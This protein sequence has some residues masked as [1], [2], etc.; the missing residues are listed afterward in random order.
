[1]TE[2]KFRNEISSFKW[3]SLKDFNKLS[4]QEGNY[5][6]IGSKRMFISRGQFKTDKTHGRTETE[7]ENKIL[8]ADIKKYIKTL[9]K[10]RNVF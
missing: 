6:V 10:W 4:I 1:M 5:I 3:I 7:I 2:Y 9:F 8:R